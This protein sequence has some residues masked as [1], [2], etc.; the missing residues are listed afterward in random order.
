MRKDKAENLSNVA[1]VVLNSPLLTEREVAEKAWVSN[2][3]AHN[4]ITELEQSWAKDPRIVWLTDKDFE[5]MESIQSVKFKRLETPENI[6]DNDLDKWENTA[7]KR[8]T[9][10]RGKAT[11]EQWGLNN[12]ES[13]DIL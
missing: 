1:K 3:T 6:N 4:M 8:Y 12:I 5:L 11:D 9:I 7:V 13:I 2:W 10:F